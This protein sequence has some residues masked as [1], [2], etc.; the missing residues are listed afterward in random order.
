[1][2]LPADIR[3]K[4]A[5]LVPRL[6]SDFEGEVVATVRAIGRTLAADGHDLHDLAD[7][8]R[9]DVLRAATR[10]VNNPDWRST[11]RFIR[12]YGAGLLSPWEAEFIESLAAMPAHWRR[13]SPK[14]EGRLD[15]IAERMR[16]RRRA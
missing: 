13:L 8:V 14:Q 3:K 9:G 10:T 7:A 4:V 16:E 6:G 1:M 11:V 15:A 5:L 2:T 12:L